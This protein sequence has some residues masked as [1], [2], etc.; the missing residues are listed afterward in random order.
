MCIS[1]YSATTNPLIMMITILATSMMISTILIHS[2]QIYFQNFHIGPRDHHND[3][4]Y[5][6]NENARAAL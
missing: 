4:H 3:I 6:E 5:L 2:L 1:A